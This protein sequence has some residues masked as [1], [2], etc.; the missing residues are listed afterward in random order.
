VSVEAR[1]I[2]LC[3]LDEVPPPGEAKRVEIEGRLPL[4]VFNLEGE[5][6]VTDDFCTHGGASLAEGFIDQDGTVECPFHQGRFDIRTGNAVAAPC[7]LPLPTYRVRIDEG[8]V[9]IELL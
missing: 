6:F 2:P 9:L 7:H 3:A 5:I 8:R 4:A 1:F